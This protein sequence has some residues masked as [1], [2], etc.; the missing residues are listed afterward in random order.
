MKVKRSSFVWWWLSTIAQTG[1]GRDGV[2]EIETEL[3][4]FYLTTL[5]LSD[6]CA[7]IAITDLS[8]LVRPITNSNQTPRSRNKPE[9]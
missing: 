2:S 3:G 5:V 7:P 9:T 4:G 8:Q 6:I 1:I